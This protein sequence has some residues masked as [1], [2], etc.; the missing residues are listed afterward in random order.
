[1]GQLLNY[2]VAKSGKK[3]N[4]MVSNWST[5]QYNTRSYCSSLA[6]LLYDFSDTIFFHSYLSSHQVDTSGDTGPAAI[7]AVR[8]CTNL[9][10]TVLYPY[11]RVS[12]S[13]MHSTLEC[14]LNY[15]LIVMLFVTFY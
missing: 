5:Y 9:D 13:Y 1:M 11:Q 8:G 3:A 7:A 6:V 2:Y 12:G 4:I 14:Y 15:C 10:I